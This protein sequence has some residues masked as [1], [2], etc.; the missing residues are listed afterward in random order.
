M[1][2][3]LEY[4][5]ERLQAQ[6]EDLFETHPDV[7]ARYPTLPGLIARLRQ[8]AEDSQQAEAEARRRAG[9][10]TAALNSAAIPAVLYNQDHTIAH[11]NPAA[12][13]LIG[14]SLSEVQTLPA[15]ERIKHFRI[16]RLDGSP[17]PVQELVGFRALCGETIV[18]EEFLF[19]PKDSQEPLHV[20]THAAP[21]RNDHN[22]ITGA[23]QTI[24]NITD[25]IQAQEAAKAASQAK[26]EFLAN[27]SHEIRTPLNGVKGMIELADKQAEQTTVKKFL[28]L[29]RQS[30]DHLMVI[31]NDIIDI[32]RIESDKAKL[33]PA[34]FS[35]RD[36][37]KATF[38]PLRTLAREKGIDFKTRVSSDLPDA[39]IG[40]ASRLRQVLENLIGNAL[41][42]THDGRVE[43][44]VERRDS[45]SGPDKAALLFTILD[46]GIGI[47]DEDQATLFEPFEQ[48][49]KQTPHQYGGSGLGLA[50]CK[51]YV[52]MMNAT[53]AF[54]SS[55]GAGTTFYLAVSFALDTQIRSE[56]PSGQNPTQQSA[57]R[58]LVAEDSRMNQI[59]IRE[60]LQELGH[61][62]V[63]V[64]DGRQAL[65]A[66]AQERFDLVLMD[67]RMPE[68]DG[69]A[70]LRIIR[71]DPPAG[72]DPHIPVIALTAYALK[73]DAKRLLGQGFDCHLPKPIDE[74]SLQ[75]A[76]LEAVP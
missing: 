45:W 26:S 20:L 39:L 67:I 46:T 38:F 4:T 15:E 49:H 19:Y 11:L 74:E 24:T 6:I 58:I 31:I 3:E 72:V 8:A 10:L 62:V 42:F 76:L 47:P 56:P 41:K 32:S 25:L 40:D 73:E 1:P 5:V 44:T 55:Q 37:L 64:E 51:H 27:M 22:E 23:V 57:L 34:P 69:E 65:D 12:E 66:L 48:G 75:Q 30:A 29:A 14:F 70:A 63:M 50:I 18:K 53:L 35:L 16:R 28:E 9:E 17:I 52:H 13:K 68:L 33:T 59:Y 43:V 21:I 60:L 7:S 71:Q 61:S 2:G 54:S 36:C